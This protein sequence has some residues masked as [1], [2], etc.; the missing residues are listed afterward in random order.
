MNYVEMEKIFHRPTSLLKRLNERFLRAEG[1]S[2]RAPLDYWSEVAYKSI[3]YR[4]KCW[5]LALQ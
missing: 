2:G 1:G 4:S 3:K 5:I